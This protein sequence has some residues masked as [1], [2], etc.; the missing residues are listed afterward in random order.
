MTNLAFSMVHIYPSGGTRGFP[1]LHFDKWV[2]LYY[3]HNFELS[4]CT[5]NFDYLEPV[6][7]SG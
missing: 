4:T 1:W 5:V 7:G 6:A 3:R 2:F